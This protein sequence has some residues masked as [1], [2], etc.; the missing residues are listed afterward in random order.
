MKVFTNATVCGAT[1]GVSESPRGCK[2]L[3]NLEN[4]AFGDCPRL[5]REKARK[6]NNC[7]ALYHLQES[8]DLK[9][10]SLQLVTRVTSF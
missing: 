2:L 5:T 10:Y 3:E 9:I 6:N 8:N 1:K 4:L 7:I